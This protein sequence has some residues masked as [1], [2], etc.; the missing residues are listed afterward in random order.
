MTK[1]KAQNDE[2]NNLI[3]RISS[4]VEI[5]ITSGVAKHNSGYVKS[6]V[7]SLEALKKTLKNLC[8]SS[9]FYYL[10]KTIIIY[11]NYFWLKIQKQPEKKNWIH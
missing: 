2:I 3:E 8:V 11:D 4:L 1:Y 9:H 5:M 6:L 10:Q 7:I